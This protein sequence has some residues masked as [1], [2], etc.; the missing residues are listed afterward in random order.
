MCL[1]TQAASCPK[2]FDDVQL[3]VR[4]WILQFLDVLN[5][6]DSEAQR[7]LHWARQ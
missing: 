4:F 2:G 7:G 1:L 3:N 5:W 6:R